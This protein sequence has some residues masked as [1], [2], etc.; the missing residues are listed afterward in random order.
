M[1]GVGTSAG[2]ATSPEAAEDEAAPTCSPLRWGDAKNDKRK[3]AK[4][5]AKKAKKAETTWLK[6]A[7]ACSIDAVESPGA[8]GPSGSAS[9]GAAAGGGGF[10]KPPSPTTGKQNHNAEYRN[11]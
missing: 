8:A 2:A 1:L 7:G 3:V 5:K 9:G 11:K 10:A 4:K 6:E